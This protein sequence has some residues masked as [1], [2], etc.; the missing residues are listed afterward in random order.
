VEAPVGIFVVGPKKKIDKARGQA[1]RTQLAEGGVP[2]RGM[3]AS[4]SVSLLRVMHAYLGVYCALTGRD[5][6]NAHHG[7]GLFVWCTAGVVV[8]SESEFESRAC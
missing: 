1:F 8:G 4:E 7:N 2:Y 6:A 3:H 5:N